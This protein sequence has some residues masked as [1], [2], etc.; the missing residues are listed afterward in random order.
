[1]V[2]KFSYVEIS[3]YNSGL[4]F[5]GVLTTLLA[6][7]EL[8]FVGEYDIIGQAQMYLLLVLMT[9]VIITFV[10]IVYIRNYLEDEI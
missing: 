9:V 7:F 6:I 5:A 3:I 2:F 8:K 10:F 1:M 4:A